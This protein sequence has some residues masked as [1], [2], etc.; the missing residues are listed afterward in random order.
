MNAY[1]ELSVKAQGF[2]HT[3]WKQVLPVIS[4]L[5]TKSPF[6]PVFLFGKQVM[7]LFYWDIE[8]LIVK[9]KIVKNLV[10]I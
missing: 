8:G 7:N 4:L 3:L 9:K 5:F 2:K 10:F 6:V 1:L